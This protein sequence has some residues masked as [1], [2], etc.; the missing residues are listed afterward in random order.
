MFSFT[1]CFSESAGNFSTVPFNLT[2]LTHIVKDVRPTR[3]RACTRAACLLGCFSFVW[4][5]LQA[6]MRIECS[7]MS[8]CIRFTELLLLSC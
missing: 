5:R 7:V 4:K 2:P 8:I 3:V 1:I 6:G